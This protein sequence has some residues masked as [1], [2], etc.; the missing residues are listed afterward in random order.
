M[1]I[2]SAKVGLITIGFIIAQ[3]AI[4]GFWSLLPQLGGWGIIG[5]AMVWAWRTTSRTQR[6]AFETAK[7]AQDRAREVDA[8][9]ITALRD[10]IGRLQAEI[11]ILRQELRNN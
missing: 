2:L 6:E 7:Q 10:E 1:D 9:T 11:T 4:E 8:A 5:G 3:E